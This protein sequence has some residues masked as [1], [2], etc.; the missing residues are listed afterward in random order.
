MGRVLTV[1]PVVPMR[2]RRLLPGDEADAPRRIAGSC[3]ARTRRL[4][5][6]PYRPVDATVRTRRG[7]V[8]VPWADSGAKLVRIAESENTL[9]FSRA[10][11]VSPR[12]SA[13]QRPARG[14][15]RL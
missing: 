1:R 5:L 9:C 8:N 14:R 3:R 15:R 10:A 7:D 2:P 11:I 6:S 13:P 4:D 12:R